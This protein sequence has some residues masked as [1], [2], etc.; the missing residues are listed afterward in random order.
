MPHQTRD[1]IVRIADFLFASNTV[2][3]MSAYAARGRYM[4]RHS[5][6]ALQR[7]FVTTTI[8]FVERPHEQATADAFEDTKCEF[9]LRRSRLPYH[10]V[11]DEHL[12]L[13][14]VAAEAH[15]DVDPAAVRAIA[16]TVI[17]ERLSQTTSEREVSHGR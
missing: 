5:T 17:E 9:E 15:P 16:S 6:G 4:A 1:A 3:A 13:C 7:L 10:H 12:T 8:E 11:K 2:R 14:E